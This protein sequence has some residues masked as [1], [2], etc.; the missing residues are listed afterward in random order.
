MN[1]YEEIVNRSRDY[2]TLINR[3]YVYEIA[4]D[5]YC[6]QIGRSR[7]D[8]VGRTVAQV[9]GDDRFERAIRPNLDRCFR[10][11]EVTFLDRFTFGEIDRHINVLFYPYRSRGRVTHALVFSHDVTRLSQ[12]E[13]RLTAYEVR[14]PTTGLFNR[15]SMEI[16]LD[17]ELERA[18]D[19]ESGDGSLALAFV[20]LE[21][22]GQ[23]VDLYG[24]QTGDLLLENTGL[25]IVRCVTNND[26]VFRFEGNELT[27]LL[28]EAQDRA[29]LSRI[30]ATIHREATLPYQHN[31]S[32][33]AVGAS[34]GISLFPG[35]GRDRDQLVRNA[36]IAMSDA[37]R[38]REPW[39]FFDEELHRAAQGRLALASE[40]GTALKE[41]NFEV[42]YQPIVAAHGRVVGAEALIRL[43]H[44]TRGL[45]M[46]AE[47]LPA[48]IESGMIVSVGRWVLFSACEQL[49]VWSAERRIFVSVNMTA[50]EFL[51]AH[52]L[53]SVE[54][55]LDQSGVDPR[56]L[57]IEITES[58]AM[59]NPD[60][61][62]ANIRALQ[63]LGVD[64][65]IDDFGTGQ[66]SLAYLR[67]LPARILKLDKSFTKDLGSPVA[68]T[69]QAKGN[70][71]DLLSRGI[72]APADGGDQGAEFLRHIVAA[73]KSLSKIVLLEGVQT[74]EQARRAAELGFDLLQGREFGLAVPASQFDLSR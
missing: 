14:D 31:E 35:D 11:E 34:I 69:E 9:W 25:R 23:I 17:K 8:I 67:M 18:A 55:A 38:R 10:G 15:R 16:I 27:I 43:N 1:A 33:L 21:N 44:P 65:L 13:D 59:A 39:V 51:D 56:R 28:T 53:E 70:G 54:N 49:R 57:K 66:S 7:S 6:R 63:R 5:A 36:H 32:T 64:V 41:Q 19:R 72:R 45:V 62:I 68:V 3:N 2:I 22:L 74:T 58:E 12:I 60:L 29:Q 4:N 46:P 50:Q 26:Y 61:A 40:V 42:Y 73:M 48:A 20:R 71:T 47:I 24:H 52:M 30:F 37:E